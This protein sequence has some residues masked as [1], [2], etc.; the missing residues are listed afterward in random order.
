MPICGMPGQCFVRRMIPIESVK[1]KESQLLEEGLQ[2]LVDDYLTQKQA[3]L[4]Q[5]KKGLLDKKAF[6]QEVE[7]QY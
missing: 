6:L 2:R 7:N 3:S 5:M 1:K 4:M